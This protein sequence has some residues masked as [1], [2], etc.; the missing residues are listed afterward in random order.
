MTIVQPNGVNQYI[1]DPRQT[2][3]LQYYF[4][5]NSE[6]FSNALQSALAAGYEESYATMI[7]S[8]LPQWLQDKVNDAQLVQKAEKNLKEFLNTQNDQADSTDKK[9]KADMTKFAL[10]RLNRKKYGQKTE[11]EVTTK[12]ITGITMLVPDQEST[13]EAL[14][15]PINDD[16]LLE[17][18]EMPQA[19]QD[20]AL[21]KPETESPMIG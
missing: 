19:S 15:S 11:L 5:E 8:R 2:L 17:T 20:A 6:T 4:D 16:S 7:V 18:H 3:F 13:P 1:A 21:P 10:E 12:A 9:I 14:Q